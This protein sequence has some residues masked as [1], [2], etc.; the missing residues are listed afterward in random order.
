MQSDAAVL[1]KRAGRGSRALTRAQTTW[2]SLRQNPAT[3]LG[4]GI[5][6]LL[7]LVAIF[8]PLIA[9]YGSLEGDP[10]AVLKPPSQAHLLGT[11][12]GGFDIFSRILYAA[13]LDLSIAAGA[14]LISLVFGTLFGAIAGYS[15]P[16]VSESVM[17]VMD[18]VSAFPGFILAMGVVAA[19][20]PSPINIVIAIGVVNIPDTTRVLRSR[21]L[22]VREMQYVT[23]ARAVGNPGWRTLL[24]HVVPNSMSPVLI[25]I[26]LQAGYAILTVAGLSFIGL[27]IRVPTAEWGVMIN[28]GLMYITTGQWW[29]AFFPGMAIAIAILGFNLLG[30][31]LQDVFD[32]RG[33]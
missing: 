24:I 12:E 25:Q 20:G 16:V 9:P 22:S 21:V 31:G 33:Q 3:M 29:V 6:V 5:V 32:R 13:R 23:A 2:H 10:S 18:M 26:T 15:G 7:I 1:E 11:D 19:L 14:I 4:L 30:D 27:G 8:G 17:R 28:M